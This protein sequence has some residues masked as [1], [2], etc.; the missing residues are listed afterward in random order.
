MGDY[1]KKVLTQIADFLKSMSPARKLAAGAIGLV[2]IGAITALFF[3]AGDTAYQPILSNGSPEDAANII[4]VLRDKRIPFKVDTSGRTVSVPTEHMLELRM[5]LASMGIA[6]SGIVGYEVFDKQ[7]IGTTSFV[8]KINQKRALEGEIMRS[9]A[10][11]KGVRRSRVHLALPQKSTFIEDQKKT[12]AS[13]VLDL[14]PGTLLSDKQVY[15][16]QNLV[17]K[18]VEGMDVADVV[19]VDSN[20]KTLSKNNADP[21]A[22]ATATQLDFKQK[23]ET[24]LEKRVE[25]M[26]GRIV[27][28]GRVVAR[29]SADLDF[30]QTA[31]TQTTYD[32]DG[33]AVRSVLKNTSSQEG[34]RPGPSGPAGATSNLPGQPPQ[35]NPMI[36]SDTKTNNETTNYEVPQTVRKTTRPSGGVKRLSVAVVLDG[37]LVK[38]PQKDGTILSKSE[39]W[40]PEKLKEFEDVVASA[41]GIDRKRGDT[42]EIKN[43]EFSREDFDEATKILAENER[44]AYFQHMI[45]YGVIGLTILL[46]FLFVVRP[47]IKWVTENTVDGVDTFLPQ[48]IEELERMQKNAQLPGMEDAVPELPDRMDPEK[49]EGEM[50]KEKITTLVES[51]PHKAALILRDWLHDPVKSRAPNDL[52]DG[53]GAPG[54]GG[55]SKSA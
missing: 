5:E 42:L 48:T 43:M 24:D 31:E 45:L 28:E 14:E 35:P 33:S 21:L 44:K 46:F 2:I 40:T 39:A 38:T 34:S 20:G 1:L 41:V 18:A 52:G 8:Q 49:V 22:V 3:W 26:L 29:V 51:N 25:D 54:G 6:Q 32:A 23:L 19:I 30:S 15:G 37:K 50:I 7:S 11:I 53:G 9:I 27:G 4:R 13:V 17:A 36:R 55:K 16:V 10:T 12:S 47:F